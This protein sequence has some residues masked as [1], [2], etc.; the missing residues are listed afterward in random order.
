MALAIKGLAMQGMARAGIM[1]TD[2]F[3]AGIVVPLVNS[4]LL[5]LVR[6]FTTITAAPMTITFNFYRSSRMPCISPMCVD[7]SF[8][9]SYKR[10]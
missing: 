8:Y 4:Y 1:P 3:W 2:L 10:V 9:C 7:I 6:Q 5:S